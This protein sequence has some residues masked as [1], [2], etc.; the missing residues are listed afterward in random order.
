MFIVILLGVLMYL[1]GWA[2][3]VETYEL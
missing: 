3:R 2:K 1:F